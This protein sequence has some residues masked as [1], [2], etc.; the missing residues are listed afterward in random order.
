MC[1]L[2]YRNVWQPVQV[3]SHRLIATA[4]INRKQ[5]FVYASTFEM[6][7]MVNTFNPCDNLA[8]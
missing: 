3:H 6:F 4:D 5:N 2:R 1:K 8:K 7:Y